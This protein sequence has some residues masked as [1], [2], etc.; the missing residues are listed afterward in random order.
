MLSMF[1]RIA[2]AF[3]RAEGVRRYFLPYVRPHLWELA[4]ALVL[5]ALVA[6]TEVLRPWPLQ[7]VF[8]FVLGGRPGH[9]PHHHG[10]EL[11]GL[12][13]SSLSPVTLVGGAAAAIVLISAVGGFGAFGQTVMLSNVGQRVVAR[14]RRDLFRHLMRLPVSFH[15]GREHGDTLLRL[16]GDIVLLRELLVGGLLDGCAALLT[17]VGTLGVMLWL[18]PRLTLA[19]LAIVPPVAIASAGLSE[20]IRRSVQRTRAKEG[21]VASRA[22]EALSAI[23][24]LQA[25]GATGKVTERFE[26][27]NR[28][29][30]RSGLKASR[31]E[32]VLARSLDLVTSAGVGV[33][34]AL[35]AWSVRT[36]RL[37]PGGLLVFFAY[38]RTLYRPIRQIARLAAR[39][40]KSAACGE[41][42]VEILETEPAIADRPDAVPCPPLAGEIGF[43]N[44]SMRYP[45]GDQA[46]SEV[47][48]SIPAGCTAVIRGE[49]GA[50]KTT[51]VSLLPR[52]IDP[53]GGRVLVDG[54][55]V[56]DFTLESLRAQ[57]AM[58]FQESVLLGFSVRENIA[59]GVPEAS[60]E[61]VE[62]A[63]W[64]AGVM[65]FAGEL[66]NGL[67]TVVGERGALLSGGQ[68]QR[69][70]LARAALRRSP[71]LV[72][73]EPFAHLDETNR[74]HVIKALREVSAGRT[75]LLVTHRDTPGLE[76]DLE[77]ELSGGRLAG[78]REHPAP[79]WRV[80]RV[81]PRRALEEAAP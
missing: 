64:R 73:D 28:S 25:F 50:G 11:F 29:G 36:G 24:V 18:E 34:L 78:L 3:P 21:S 7:V 2:S 53:T 38:Q 1:R 54:R 23:A 72:L 43:D 81:V 47:S 13:L 37:S 39:S 9:H 30:L 4:G 14:I 17:L 77:I 67:D 31:L 58:V 16:T 41:R 44:V 49:S 76:P 6:L 75:V 46:L 57:V 22:G 26:R 48:F 60:A 33:T 79:A 8:D 52:L 62:Q 19:S 51:L 66:P 27:E 45:R 61:E 68:R 71:I 59:L 56:R 42:I 20:R 5:G 32:A 55:D 40:A 63:A 12:K 35:G 69:V 70:A 15:T 80:A 10:Q 74:D 65:R